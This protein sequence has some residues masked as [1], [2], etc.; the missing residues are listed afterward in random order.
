MRLLYRSVDV[1]QQFG[2]TAGGPQLGV[3]NH[4]GGL[5]DALILI[6]ALDRVPRFIGRDVIWKYPIA[7]QGMNFVGAIPVHKP[8]DSA[9]RGA[10]RNDQMFASTYAA[11]EEEDLVVIFPE[12]ITVDHPSIAP[13]KTGA[14]RIALGARA[15]GVAGIEIV[16]SGIHY[17]DKALLR[18]KVYVHVGDPID[19]DAWVDEH[20]RPGGPQ[21]SSN[22]QL[23]TELTSTIENSLRRAAP[24]FDGWQEARSLQRASAI[25]LRSPPGAPADVDYGDQSALAD[26]LATRPAPS[27]GQITSTL[28]TYV[29]DL[30]AAGL[31]DEQMMTRQRSRGSFLWRVTWN[32]LIGLLLLPFAIVG[33]VINIVPMVGVWLVGKARVDPAMMATLKPGAAI[34][35]FSV[36]WGIAAWAGWRWQGLAG[37]GAVL[38]LMPLYLYALV[39]LVERGTLLARALRGRARTQDLHEGVLEHRGDVVEAVVEAI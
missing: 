15:S 29:A 16:P 33:L 37:V 36:T 27:K 25:A 3:A 20:T 23:V 7:K 2:E 6:Y 4:F 26:E 18:S 12:G 22:R 32:G 1:H 13:I 21:D 14:A 24:N 5:S 30:D 38:L 31:S 9:G 17:E 11:L 34:V 28:D 10:V 39:A 35:M 8:D 19:L